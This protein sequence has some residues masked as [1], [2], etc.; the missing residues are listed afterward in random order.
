MQDHINGLINQWEELLIINAGDT[1]TI[2]PGLREDYRNQLG[3]DMIALLDAMSGLV[4]NKNHEGE[5]DYIGFRPSDCYQMDP[6]FRCPCTRPYRHDPST[7]CRA[8]LA[9][10]YVPT[11]PGKPKEEGVTPS[12][13]PGISAA[14]AVNEAIKE[15]NP[16]KIKELHE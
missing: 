10:E 16:K 5:P 2:D 13:R 6:V 15:V 14:E 3:G 12:V 7:P 11:E 8:D 4:D 9:S 1:A